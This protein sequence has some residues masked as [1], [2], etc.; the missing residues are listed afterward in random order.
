M[1]AL[2][3]D[4]VPNLTVSIEVFKTQGDKIL[5]VALS[6]IGDKGLFTKEIE[7]AL[8]ENKVDLAVHSMKDLPSV[9]EPGFCIGAV[10]PR[11]NP[12][13]VLLSHRGYS[14]A[15]L[16][17]GARVGTSSLRRI[18]QLKARRPDVVIAQLRGNV[19]T[20]IEKM[21]REGLDAI[22]LA[23]AGVKR[24]GYEDMI[25][26]ILPRDVFL[27]AVGQG[28]IGVE[29]RSADE[30]TARLAALIN[31]EQTRLEVLAERAFLR[32]LEGGCQVPIGAMAEIRGQDL[33]LSGMVAALDGA[34]IYQGALQGQVAEAE[35]IGCRLARQLLA[36]GADEIL[37]EIG[38]VG[39]ET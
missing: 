3:Q 9:L 23:Y 33:N 32:V 12:Q 11:E 25:T 10:L 7:L 4:A 37:A 16:P 20:R 39:E 31:H 6:R 36:Q 15:T 26:D 22:V 28:A 2:L 29:I 18:A 24:L 17:Q 21:R 1:A 30:A 27:P 35:E 13:D 19:G 5:D 38:R 34:V 14:F 8:L